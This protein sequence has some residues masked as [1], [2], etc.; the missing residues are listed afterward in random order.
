M[1]QAQPSKQL[2]PVLTFVP[3]SVVLSGPKVTVQAQLQVD[4]VKKVY[5]AREI[6]C[7]S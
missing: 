7:M 3:F 6:T 1:Q 4:N 2:R 5:V